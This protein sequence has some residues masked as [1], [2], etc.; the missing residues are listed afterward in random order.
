MP[1]DVVVQQLIST[2]SSSSVSGIQNESLRLLSF[3]LFR[4]HIE[5]KLIEM[6]TKSN[7]NSQRLK[8]IKSILPK[9]V[10]FVEH[11]TPECRESCF[12]LLGVIQLYG[13]LDF[14]EF[15]KLTDGIFDESRRVK[16]QV[17]HSLLKD[18]YEQ[19]LNKK[20]QLRSASKQSNSVVVIHGGG[21]D[22]GMCIYIDELG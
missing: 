6:T 4:Q 16:I 21:D 18:Q 22:S 19:E 14:N 11:K 7:Q 1:L 20:M 17:A 5:S 10:K 12:R 3:S 15:A 13:N 8:L 9:I 2:L